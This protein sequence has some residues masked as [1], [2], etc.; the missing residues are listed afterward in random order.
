MPGIGGQISF[1]VETE[2][3]PRKLL[4]TILGNRMSDNWVYQKRL[5]A[6]VIKNEM[7]P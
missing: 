2:H 6:K 7:Q 3:T 5:T 1:F 4:G